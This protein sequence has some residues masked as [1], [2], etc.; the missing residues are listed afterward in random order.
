M[1]CSTSPCSHADTAAVAPSK[2]SWMRTAFFL[3]VDSPGWGRLVEATKLV[4][5]LCFA[6]LTPCPSGSMRSRRREE[7]RACVS[8]RTGFP[9]RASQKSPNTDVGPL[10]R[11]SSPIAAEV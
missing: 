5:M 9:Y 3:G 7:G 10:R 4:Y 11:P 1:L 8:S 6:S 2:I